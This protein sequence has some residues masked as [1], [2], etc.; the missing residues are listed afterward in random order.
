MSVLIL[1][2]IV[3]EGP[4]TLGDFLRGSGIDC[5][6]IELEHERIPDADKYETL[7]MLGG[8]MS[9]NNEKEYPYLTGE[10]RLAER[11]MKEGRKVFGICL[12]SQI[13]AK[14][15]GARVYAGPI[16]E[17]G[18][19]D[20]QLSEKG[21]DDAH[22]RSL[23]R[24]TETG[25]ILQSVRVFH[26]HGETFDLPVGAELLAGSALYPHQ[27]FRY[28]EQAYAF[29]FHIEVSKEMIAEW[30]LTEPVDRD[31]LRRQTEVMYSGFFEHAR[32]FYHSFFASGRTLD[33]RRLTQGGEI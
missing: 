8:P 16:K 9:V 12:G 11:F 17:L 24:S 22:M 19:F 14:A 15:L 13:M 4:G 29:Q 20:I 31:L 6:I 30:A 1:K 27:A 7:V 23:A 10:I 25:E 28:G 2:N 26:W 32:G 5:R 21:L 33:E 3:S 18:W